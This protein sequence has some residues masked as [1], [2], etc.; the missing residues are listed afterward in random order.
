MK[1]VI[2]MGGSILASPSP[3]VGIIKD[4][5]K[6]LVDYHNRGHGLFVVV[7]GGRLARDYIRVAKELGADEQYCDEIGIRATRMNAMLLAA[8]LGDRGTGNI[9]SDLREDF[10]S[11]DD[12]GIGIF[13]MGGVKPGQTTDAV[14]AKLASKVKAELLINATNVDGVYDSD[15][16]ENPDA[17]KFDRL[18]YDGLLEIV[19]EKH[20]AGV[21]TVIDPIAARVIKENEIRTVILNGK[22]LENVKNAID[23]GFHGGTVVTA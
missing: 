4:F 14:A 10:E 15:P 5:A 6:L 21:N 7:G 22:R 11:K 20:R 23:G 18:T 3:N 19:G 9:A 2:S 16:N 8:A 17:K 1:I 13:V 12:S